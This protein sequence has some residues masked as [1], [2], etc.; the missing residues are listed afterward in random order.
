[1]KAATGSTRK[2]P[3]FL[4]LS[5][6]LRRIKIDSLLVLLPG[7]TWETNEKQVL[8]VNIKIARFFAKSLFHLLG[9]RSQ[10]IDKTHIKFYNRERTAKTNMYKNEAWY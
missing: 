7:V 6:I 9:Y 1:M 5:E 3:I 2:L 4:K 8:K 10:T